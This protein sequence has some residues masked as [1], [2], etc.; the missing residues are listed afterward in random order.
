MSKILVVVGATGQ[1]GSSI[2]NSILSDPKLS[3]EY[4]IRGTTRDPNS[5]KAQALAAKGIEIV[6]ANF[7]E[8]E[9]LQRAFTGAHTVFANTPTIYD[10]HTYEHEVAHGRALIDAAVAVG[11][12][13]YI[14]STLPSIS[15]ISQGWLKNGGHFDGKEEVEQYIRTQPIRSAF[16]AP[17]SFMSNFHDTMA[18]R[19]MENG[20]YALLLPVP[21]HIRLPLIETEADLGK[22]VAAILADFDQYEGK[23]LCCATALYSFEDIVQTMSRVSG[24]TVTYREVPVEIWATYLPELMRGYIVDMFTLFRVYGYN[25]DGTEEKVKWSAEQARGELTTLEEYLRKYPLNLE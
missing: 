15:K 2:I 21:A 23:V 25:G 20:D 5:S 7:N 16:V 9:S 14:Y 10:G 3:P 6:V 17:G 19:S 22:W 18:P 1:Q 11:V 13:F 12:P 8:P 24:K 4:T